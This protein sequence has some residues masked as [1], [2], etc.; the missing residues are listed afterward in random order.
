MRTGVAVPGATESDHMVNTSE[1]ALI[2]ALYDASARPEQWPAALTLLAD[3]LGAHGGILVRNARTPDASSCVAGRIAPDI[4][5]TYV[6]DYTSNPWTL[7]AAGVPVGNVA[8]LSQLYDLRNGR[9]L[10]WYADI[11]QPTRT[12]DMAY[13]ALPGFTTPESVGGIAL[14]FAQSGHAA[15]TAAAQRM[16]ELRPHLS[17]A[18]WL[19]QHV[20]H[21]RVLDQRLEDLLLGSARPTLLLTAS[22]HITD[23]NEAAVALLREDRGLKV[24][25]DGRLQASSPVD[26]DALRAALDRASNGRGHPSR[27]APMTLQLT[28]TPPGS[29]HVS[30]TALTGSH[31]LPRPTPQPTLLVTVVDRSPRSRQLV[32][33]LR[34]RFGLTV[35]ESDVAAVLATGIGRRAAATHLAVSVETVKKHSAAIF[36]KTGTRSQT[37]LANLVASI[38]HDLNGP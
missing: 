19:S 36:H 30:V 31:T 3:Q 11:L 21:A 24:R 5:A 1:A 25:P 34:T 15:V 9:H 20:D 28:N 23:A 4:V 38:R 27:P 14:C 29:Y 37:E 6:R 16:S 10:Q 18:V 22:G 33:A 26:D 8:V 17:R 13:L 12:M 35:R 32:T 2:D 7:A